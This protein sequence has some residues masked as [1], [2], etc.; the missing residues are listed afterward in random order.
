MSRYGYDEKTP[1]RRSEKHDRS[2][3]A[4]CQVAHMANSLAKELTGRDRALAYRIKAAAC[5][6]LI[7]AGAANLNGVRAN[8]I[9][10]LDIL[11]DIQRSALHIPLTELEPEARALVRVQA[12]STRTV[13]PLIEC[14]RPEQLNGLASHFPAKKDRAA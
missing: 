3:C 10:G 1:G 13:A 8:S 5:S 11:I 12:K 6:A 4:L 9:L 2:L 7:V 14:L